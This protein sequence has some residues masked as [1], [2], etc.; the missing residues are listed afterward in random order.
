MGKKYKAPK[1]SNLAQHCPFLI[2]SCEIGL[3]E[4]SRA[5]A[6]ELIP[7]TRELGS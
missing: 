6:K 4:G 1:N 5:I 2:L 7:D 3:Q